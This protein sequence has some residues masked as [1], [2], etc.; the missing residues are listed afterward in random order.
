ML[1][2]ELEMT[3]NIFTCYF[4]KLPSSRI[5]SFVENFQLLIVFK[6]IIL[7]ISVFCLV[8]T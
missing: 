4:D 1:F 7:I 6:I 2:I 3:G 8:L 5:Q